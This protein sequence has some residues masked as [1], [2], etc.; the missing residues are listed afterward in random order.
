[1]N[2]IFLV[3]I[4]SL[5]AF[6][7]LA[8]D[9]FVDVT[10]WAVWVDANSEGTFNSPNANQ[11]FDISFDGK[12][13]YGAG[14]NVFFSNRISIEV[15]AA[16]VKQGVSFTG[17]TRPAGAAGGDLNMVPITG[18]LQ[19][20]LLPN[21]TIDPYVGAGAAYILF[22]SVDDP[23]DFGDLNV[24]S[25]DFKDDAG[26]ALNAG[27]SFAIT[28]RLAINVDG[29]YVPLKSN[30]KAVFVT[31]PDSTVKVDINPAIFSAGLSFRF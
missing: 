18:V 13:G 17:R 2:R 24:R 28:P 11:P 23:R 21:G 31:G 14:V 5:L 25:I 3:V 19:F 1:M 9:R 8:A 4:L 16:A 29:K 15:M 20:H 10:G 30:A 6:P 27:I 12:L 22:D 7:V 26:L